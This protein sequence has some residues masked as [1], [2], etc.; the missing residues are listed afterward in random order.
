MKSKLIK[1]EMRI[2]IFLS[3]LLAILLCV[4]CRENS[5]KRPA[6]LNLSFSL[7]E[8]SQQEDK[9]TVEELRFRPIMIKLSAQHSSGE[10]VDFLRPAAENDFVTLSGN[11]SAYAL[12]FDV[13]QGEYS[14]FALTLIIAPK[15]A[16]EAMEIKGRF[17]FGNPHWEDAQVAIFVDEEQEIDFDLVDAQTGKFEIKAGA[18]AEYNLQFNP[19]FWLHGINGQIMRQAARTF[20]GNG[21][22]PQI[23]INRAENSSI[24]RLL[25][26]D[27][28]QG[29][30]VKRQ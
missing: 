6:R 26:Q 27:F 9:I 2:I 18:G 14:R 17:D 1:K 24:Y 16:Q 4:G 8:E 22:R 23:R 20:G 3:A 29:N 12:S 11:Q 30:L 28:G 21:N 15:A 25:L 5:W 10:E 13:P 7:A 19:I